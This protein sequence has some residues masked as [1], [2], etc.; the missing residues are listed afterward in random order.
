MRG[1]WVN[2]S[3][4]SARKEP[5]EMAARLESTADPGRQFWMARSLRQTLSMPWVPG[6]GAGH[7][8]LEI[9]FPGQ[10]CA[11]AGMTILSEDPPLSYRS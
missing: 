7:D 1:G 9:I 2:R 11:F 3:R 10:P 4:D 5:E 8:E 6:T